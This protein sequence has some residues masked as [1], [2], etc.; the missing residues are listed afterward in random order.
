M[1]MKNKIV[2]RQLVQK[3]SYQGHALGPRSFL[4]IIIG[5]FSPF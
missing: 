3:F 5:P 2:F 1:G 4:K